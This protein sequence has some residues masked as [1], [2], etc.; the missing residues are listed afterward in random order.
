[1]KFSV[2]KC[3]A[4]LL[5]RGMKVRWKEIELPDKEEIY[6]ADSGGYRYLG[7]LMCEEMKR[8]ARE[9]YQKRIKL[10]RQS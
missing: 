10:L 6:E 2:S 9:V 1:M 8:K 7:M 3:A 5:L 4:V